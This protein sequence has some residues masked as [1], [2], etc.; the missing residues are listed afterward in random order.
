MNAFWTAIGSAEK[1][2]ELIEALAGSKAGADVLIVLL[3]GGHLALLVGLVFRG[4]VAPD[5]RSVFLEGCCGVLA[6]L[7]LDVFVLWRA[8][9]AL[10]AKKA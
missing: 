1:R 10:T 4:L 2:R 9:R 6:L 3:A 5:F 8:M 7:L